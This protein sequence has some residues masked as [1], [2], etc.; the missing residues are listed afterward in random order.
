M[1]DRV[2]MK[3][4]TAAIRVLAEQVD[5]WESKG[6]SRPKPARRARKPKADVEEGDQ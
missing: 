4:G 1:S 6:Y 3:R 2:E 5:Y